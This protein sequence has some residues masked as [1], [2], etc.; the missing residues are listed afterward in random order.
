MPW[1]LAELIAYPTNF[2][3]KI[4]GRWFNA[5]HYIHID[6]CTRLAATS[7]DDML[8]YFGARWATYPARWPTMAPYAD[9]DIELE[10]YSTK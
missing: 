4:A 3:K 6:G 5:Y 10:R 8:R 7:G 9:A 2:G 1:T